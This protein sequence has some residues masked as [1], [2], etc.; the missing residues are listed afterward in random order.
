MSLLVDGKNVTDTNEIHDRMSDH[1]KSKFHDNSLDFEGLNEIGPLEKPITEEEVM[2]SVRKMPNGRA[3]GFDGVKVEHIKYGPRILITT[4]TEMLND[5]YSQGAEHPIG[6]GVLIPLQKPGKKR[7]PL[8]NFR[9]VILLPV[10][11]KIL[12]T[13]VLART[14]TATEEYLAP[15]QS[16][17]RTGRSTTDIVWTHKWLIA[18]V[19]KYRTEVHITGVDMSSAFDTINRQKLLKI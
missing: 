17:Y 19:L 11:R 5:I 10:L 7:G 2:E 18:R 12:S 4:L 16:A 3:A 8:K 14:K 6:R 9:P 1:F 13:I 15:S